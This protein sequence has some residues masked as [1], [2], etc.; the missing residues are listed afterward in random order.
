MTQ[1]LKPALYVD[2]KKCKGTKMIKAEERFFQ[3]RL[4]LLFC[5]L[6]IQDIPALA[7]FSQK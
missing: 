1:N 5:I 6:K 7:F 3:A 2:Q 4:L